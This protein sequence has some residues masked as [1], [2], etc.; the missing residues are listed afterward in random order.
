MPDLE[1]PEVLPRPVAGGAEQAVGW[2][3]WW[4]LFGVV[5]ALILALVVSKP[6]P[7]RRIVAFMSDGIW[8]TIRI[9]VISYLCILIVGLIAGLGRLA[10]SSLTRGIASVYVEVI[11]GIPLLVQLMF[12][13]Y[14]SP[15]VIQAFGR[16]LLANVPFLAGLGKALASMTID[17]FSGAVFALTLCYGAY[18]GEIYRAG[19]Q[20]IPRG[21]MEAARSLGMTHW[22]AM[23]YVILPQAIRNIL[24]PLGNEFVALLKDSSLVSVVAVADMTRR[25]REFMSK[26]FIPLETMAMVALL[27]LLMTVFAARIVS[28]IERKMSYAR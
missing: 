14:A 3:R 24:P 25:G 28:Y 27:Y 16:W 9:T 19:I 17:P 15:I 13:Y 6:D 21:Q 12:I 4:I 20:A 10:K 26:T 22:Q 23:R 2:D 5:A 18:A 11:R 8:I 1:K 7:Y